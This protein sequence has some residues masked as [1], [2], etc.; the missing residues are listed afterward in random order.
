MPLFVL[1]AFVLIQTASLVHVCIKPDKYVTA[2]VPLCFNF[3]FV[4]SGGNLTPA[5]LSLR[6][7]HEQ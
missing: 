7:E 3:L 5:S 1:I 6:C 2:A 4:A